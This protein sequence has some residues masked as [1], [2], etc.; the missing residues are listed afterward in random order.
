V[1]WVAAAAVTG[2]S[3]GATMAGRCRR[4][5]WHAPERHAVPPVVECPRRRRRGAGGACRG[6]QRHAL[7]D[8]AM[9]WSRGRE[10]CPLSSS[11][12]DGDGVG[13][14]GRRRRGAVGGSGMSSM[15]GGAMHVFNGDGVVEGA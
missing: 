2:M 12:L 10:E 1:S 5:P 8:A 7:D 13:Q 15:T 6:W 4:V 9:G 3:R 14:V 11:V